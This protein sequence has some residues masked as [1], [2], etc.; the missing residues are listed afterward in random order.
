MN[1]NG[2]IF[3]HWLSNLKSLLD[4]NSHRATGRA[5]RRCAGK[6]A[7]KAADRLMQHVRVNV[8]LCSGRC[9]AT[10]PGSKHLCSLCKHLCMY[11]RSTCTTCTRSTCIK[12]ITTIA[13]PGST[14]S[15][16]G[17]LISSAGAVITRALRA[18]VPIHRL[19]TSSRGTL[20][21]M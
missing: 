15:V 3:C 16:P 8:P 19:C 14:T 21:F 11:T 10:G 2:V 1:H 7:H 17:K 6:P 5:F 20:G 13:M 18:Q 12:I 4:G 9:M